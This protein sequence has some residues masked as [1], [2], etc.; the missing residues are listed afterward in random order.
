MTTPVMDT[1]EIAVRENAHG[2][3]GRRRVPFFAP[4]AE[5]YYWTRSWQH[6]EAEA[7]AD[8]AAGRVEVFSSGASA[9]R[10]LLASEDDED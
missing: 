5:L 10:S 3:G 4:S 1:Y 2:T 7:L 6:G 8:V 9:A